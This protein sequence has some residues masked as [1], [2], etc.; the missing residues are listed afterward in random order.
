MAFGQVP[1]APKYSSVHLTPLTITSAF[2]FLSNHFAPS[3]ATGKPG[4][5]KLGTR[6][7][8]NGFPRAQSTP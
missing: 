7:Y 3:E 6:S 8:I 2:Q 5:A 4:Y 1:Q